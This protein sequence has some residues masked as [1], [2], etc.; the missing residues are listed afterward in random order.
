[1][2][3]FPYGTGPLL[4]TKDTSRDGGTSAHW[5]GSDANDHKAILEVVKRQLAGSY[6]GWV[7]RKT[8]GN[9]TGI[10]VHTLNVLVDGYRKTLAPTSTVLDGA[11]GTYYVYAKCNTGNAGVEVATAASEPAP[12]STATRDYPLA[13]V[14]ITGGDMSISHIRPDAIMGNAGAF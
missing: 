2:A 14:Y 5:D 8:S 9:L 6:R 10:L 3:T 7:S 1:M 11:T 4:E 12:Y 13:S